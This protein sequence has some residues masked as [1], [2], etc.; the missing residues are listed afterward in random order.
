MNNDANQ[1]I[2]DSMRPSAKMLPYEL[3]GQLYPG[4][5]VLTPRQGPDRVQRGCV[6]SVSFASN[7]RPWC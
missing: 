2:A 6:K 4:V 1:T 5:S 3:D 7:T